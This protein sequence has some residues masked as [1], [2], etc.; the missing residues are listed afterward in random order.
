MPRVSRR[1]VLAAMS[2]VGSATLAGCS[3]D[4]E[5]STTPTRTATRTAT[6]TPTAT[7]TPQTPPSEAL[8]FET[9][10]AR[11][12]THPEMPAESYVWARYLNAAGV[13]GSVEDENIE[14]RL[15]DGWLGAGPPKYT[16][17]DAIELVHVQPGGL[18]NVTFGRGDYDASTAVEGMVGDGWRQQGSTGG[19]DLLT[20][21]GYGAAVGDRQWIIVSDASLELVEGL[22][23]ASEHDPLDTHLDGV[24]RTAVSRAVSESGNYRVVQRSVPGD[25]AAG[26][27]LDYGAYRYPVGVM[28]YATGRESPSWQR[29]ENRFRT[30]IAG[31]LRATDFGEDFG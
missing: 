21:G 10:L 11:T 26:I 22:V 18:A 13:L 19:Y 8:G 6:T 28:H 12:P 29:V 31:E 4:G 20:N 15:R 2:A 7:S 25:Y 30:Q 1:R 3:A 16:D 27:S 5:T 24:D 23:A 17:S 9:M 14:S